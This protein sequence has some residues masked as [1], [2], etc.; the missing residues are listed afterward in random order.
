[1]GVGPALVPIFPHPIVRLAPVRADILSALPQHVSR[2][3][4]EIFL[5]ANE[6]RNGF[7]HFAV[8][9]ELHLLACSVTDARR[10]RISVSI[11]M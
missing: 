6:M 11:K 1:M 10:T 8:K 3:A 7:H 9:V 4:I 5:F 2:V